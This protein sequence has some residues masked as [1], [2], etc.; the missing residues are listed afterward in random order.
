MK[1]D[2]E[3]K[4]ALAA[5]RYESVGNARRAAGKLFSKSPQEKA[6]AMQLINKHFGVDDTKSAAPAKKSAAK[7][8][9]VPKKSA[10][11]A[12]KAAAAPAK[13][14]EPKKAG[15]KPRAARQTDVVPE[16]THEATHTPDH[17]FQQAITS[18]H[19]S[20]ETLRI[21]RDMKDPANAEFEREARDTLRQ[22]IRLVREIIGGYLSAES[23]E[24]KVV[25][26]ES[27]E[28]P[29]VDSED[30]EKEAAE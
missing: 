9:A 5:G 23:A 18:A 1:N 16:A 21:L 13:K 8:T 28:I 24:V 11:P 22:S 3:F 29:T 4:T 10:A 7:K 6:Q 2:S 30:E 27:V 20:G 12:K 19:V 17:V 25:V 15:R 14:A 26:T